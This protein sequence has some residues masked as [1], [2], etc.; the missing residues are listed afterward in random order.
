M[1]LTYTLILYRNLLDAPSRKFVVPNSMIAPSLRQEMIWAS[2]L[3]MRVKRL[4]GKDQDRLVELT[5]RLVDNNGN[6]KG[7][8]AFLAFECDYFAGTITYVH[9]WSCYVY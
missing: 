6:N 1:D 8:Q 3:R 4:S 2:D 5:S 7:E 9:E